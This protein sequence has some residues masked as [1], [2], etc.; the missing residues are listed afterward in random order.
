MAWLINIVSI[1]ITIPD[2]RSPIVLQRQRT[3][4]SPRVIVSLIGVLR[5]DTLGAWITLVKQ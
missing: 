2:A 3:D 5:A 4:A 1:L